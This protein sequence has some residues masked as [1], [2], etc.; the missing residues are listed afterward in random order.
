MSNIDPT[1]NAMLAA[2]YRKVAEVA[3]NRYRV[4]IETGEVEVTPA[5]L[6]SLDKLSARLKRQNELHGSLEDLIDDLI[7]DEIYGRNND[8]PETIH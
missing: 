4:I 3:L 5:L 7:D 2:M 8:A 1:S 6:S